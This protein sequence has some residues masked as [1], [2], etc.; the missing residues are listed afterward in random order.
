M[1]IMVICQMMYYVNIRLTLL[2]IIPMQKGQME[3]R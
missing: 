3:Q 2:A 1:T